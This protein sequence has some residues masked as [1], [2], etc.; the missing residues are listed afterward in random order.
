MATTKCI[1]RK[2]QPD[3]NGDCRIIILY[4]QGNEAALKI[5]LGEK[6]NP[7]FFDDLKGVVI[8]HS[9]AKEI[10]HIISTHINYVNDII[11]D[12]KRLRI[13]P[14]TSEVKKRYEKYLQE[15]KKQKI[16]KPKND[17]NSVKS[18]FEAWNELIQLKRN[19]ISNRSISIYSTTLKHLVS[20][21]ENR[22]IELRWELFDLDFDSYWSNYFLEECEGMN[23]EIGMSNNTIGKYVKTLKQFLN[24]A[25]L[26]GYHT[27]LIY[28]N[29]KIYSEYGDIFPLR[30]SHLVKMIEFANDES[31]SIKLRKTASLFIFLCF[32][33]L[34]YHDAKNLRAHDIYFIGQGDIT[35]E[36]IRFRTE[37][38]DQKLI[39]ALNNYSIRELLRNAQWNNSKELVE[40][41]SNSTGVFEWGQT[42]ELLHKM[43]DDSIFLLPQLSL[44]KFNKYIKEVG[45]LCGFNEKIVITRKKGTKVE[46][47]VL[48]RHEK[49]SSHD[50]RR[51]FITI[52]LRK[53][54]R[55]ETLMEFTGHKSYKTMLRYNKIDEETRV[56]EF[57]KTWGY[58]VKSKSNDFKSVVTFGTIH[59][60]KNKPSL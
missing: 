14:T 10:N 1:I 60:I 3:K 32:S 15:E 27:S 16:I 58:S 48:E 8:K 2:D 26:K 34:R 53:G 30:E 39:V 56:E 36:V 41:F 17:F 47:L 7:H 4:R 25:V 12:L 24:W 50:G 22:D 18:V 13:K 51:T 49:L 42:G 37:K 43:S 35:M 45:K 19:K 44:V 29:Y 54:M 52:N 33:G 46:K 11:F 28:K 5:S 9:R 20:F 31:Q 6:I 57:Q 23:G 21:C 59:S 40:I 38:T 55:P